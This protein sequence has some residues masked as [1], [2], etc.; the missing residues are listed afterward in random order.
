MEN[1]IFTVIGGDL[2][3]VKLANQLMADGNT[4]YIYGFNNAGFEMG[5]TE[6]KELE[7]AIIKSEV[8]IGPIPCSNDN[9]T[10]NAPFHSEKIHI[11]EVF[12]IMSKNQLFIAGRIGDKIAHLAEIYNVYTIDLL[13]REEMAVLNAIPTAEG[14]IQIAMEEIPITLHDCNCLI[15]GF[16][17]IGKILGKMLHG[18]GSNVFIEARKYSDMAWIKS[19]GFN[20]VFINELNDCLSDM[21]VIFNTIPYMILDTNALSKLKSDCLIIDL[22]SKPGGVDFEKAKSM[23]IKA[24]WALSLPGKV[25]PVTAAKFI[26]ETINNIICELGV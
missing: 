8:V 24:I 14:A 26:K 5:M 12:K 6:S 13:D 23:G 7:E 16:G 17:R 22:A 25:A 15:L 9:E 3:S 2:R 19:Y 1:K 4:V 18:I 20:A 11:N 21:D 10:I